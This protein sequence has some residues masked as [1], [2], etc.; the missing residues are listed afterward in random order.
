MVF[1]KLIPGSII[2]EALGTRD[3]NALEFMELL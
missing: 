1:L 2:K 3:K